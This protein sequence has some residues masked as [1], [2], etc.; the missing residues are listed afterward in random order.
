MAIFSF[1]KLEELKIK[2]HLNHFVLRI[3]LLTK[4]NQVSF[5]ELQKFKSKQG[6]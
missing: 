4:V 1:F 3:K 2:H 6:Q 5:I